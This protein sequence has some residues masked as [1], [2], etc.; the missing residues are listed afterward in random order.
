MQTDNDLALYPA[1]VI[2]L[3]MQFYTGPRKGAGKTSVYITPSVRDLH[4]G[5]LNIP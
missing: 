3:S 4:W 1:T 5:P 2:L